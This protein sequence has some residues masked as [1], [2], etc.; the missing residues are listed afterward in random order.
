MQSN[1]NKKVNAEMSDVEGQASM[2]LIVS[3]VTSKTVD[4]SLTLTS[5]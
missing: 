1:G 3:P 4:G 2:S 5:D